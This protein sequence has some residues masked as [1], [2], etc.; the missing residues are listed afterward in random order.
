MYFA[1]LLIHLGIAA[2]LAL[3]ACIFIDEALELRR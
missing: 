3:I 2:N 1:H